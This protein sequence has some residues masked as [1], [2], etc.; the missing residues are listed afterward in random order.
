MG[1]IVIGILLT[2]FVETS[3]RFGLTINIKKTGVRI[4][5][6][7]ITKLNPRAVLLNDTPLAEVEKFTYLDSTVTNNGSIDAEILKRIQ[8]AASAFGKLKK[9]WD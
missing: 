3:K 8:S 5:D 9:I 2:T 7:H 4:Q 1:S 6:T